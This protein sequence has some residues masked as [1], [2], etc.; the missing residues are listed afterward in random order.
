MYTYNLS[1]QQRT[2]AALSRDSSENTFL[3]NE[4][5]IAAYEP[6]TYAWIYSTADAS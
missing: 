5:K 1:A 6:E 4:K 2:N 3:R